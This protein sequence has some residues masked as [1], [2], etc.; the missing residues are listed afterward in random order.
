MTWISILD[1]DPINVFFFFFLRHCKST[2]VSTQFDRGHS[3]AVSQIPDIRYHLSIM[4]IK[5]WLDLSLQECGRCHS[6]KHSLTQTSWTWGCRGFLLVKSLWAMEDRE[7]PIMWHICEGNR[8]LDMDKVQL[9]FLSFFLKQQ[10]IL[11]RG[12]GGWGV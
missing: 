7:S 8:I 9:F 3:C 10:V 2:Q 6:L 11:N 4:M 12:A 5:A 1:K